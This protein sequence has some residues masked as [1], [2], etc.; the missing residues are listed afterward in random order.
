MTKNVTDLRLKN[1]THLPL[2][3]ARRNASGGQTIALSPT[4]MGQ[5]LTVLHHAALSLFWVKGH[6]LNGQVLIFLLSLPLGVRS[7]V[8]L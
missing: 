4:A 3:T 2:V 6:F 8:S 1:P 7:T 5:A